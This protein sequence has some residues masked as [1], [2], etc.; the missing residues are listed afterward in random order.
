MLPGGPRGPQPGFV[1]TPGLDVHWQYAQPSGIRDTG[2]GPGPKLLLAW[3]SSIVS[4]SRTGFRRALPRGARSAHRLH[5]SAG[6]VPGPRPPCLSWDED[7]PRRMRRHKAHVVGPGH[8]VLRHR[9]AGPSTVA[10]DR[11]HLAGERRRPPLVR[12]PHVVLA[13]L[14]RRFA[15]STHC[16]TS[17]LASGSSA[18]GGL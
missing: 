13:S 4:T 5:Q 10:G 15:V 2:S 3:P 17:C 18:L 7:I 6:F 11:C 16:V 12:R 8:V 1:T 14:T 9:G